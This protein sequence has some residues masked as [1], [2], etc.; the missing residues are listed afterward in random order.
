MTAR[1]GDL[2]LLDHPVAHTRSRRLS[3]PSSRIPDGRS[4][5]RLVCRWQYRTPQVIGESSTANRVRD[6]EGR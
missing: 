2:E 4:L 1:A 3:Q 6:S 5:N